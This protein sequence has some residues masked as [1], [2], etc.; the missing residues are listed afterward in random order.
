MKILKNFFC[1][2]R[3]VYKASAFYRLHNKHRLVVLTTDFVAFFTLYCRVL[4]IQIVKL[5]LNHFDL[6]ILGKDRIQNFCSVVEGNSHMF[7][8]SFFFQCKSSLVCM[9]LFKVFKDLRTLCMHQIIIKILYSTGFQ[10]LLKKRTDIF[11]FLEIEICQFIGKNKLISFMSV[12]EACLNSFLTFSLKITM[13]SIKVVKPILQK[14]I[15][16]LFGLLDIH[17]ITVHWKSHVTKNK[18]FFCSIQH[19]CILLF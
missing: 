1:L 8:F 14:I 4:I 15:Y 19:C 5:D 9:A 13:S 7:Y 18:M 10:L 3:K 6:R 2:L 11:L 16:H 17:F 12:S